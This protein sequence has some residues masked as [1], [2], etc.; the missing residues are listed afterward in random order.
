VRRSEASG[1]K[2]DSSTRGARRGDL[3]G[4]RIDAEASR[5]LTELQ[6]LPFHPLAGLFPLLEGADFE[7]LIADVRAMTVHVPHQRDLFDTD[8]PLIGLHV[9]LD[10]DID[11]RQPCHDNIAEI[12]SGCGPHAYALLCATCGQFRGWLPKAAATFIAEAI[13]VDGIPDTPLI[14]RDA[15]HNDNESF[16]AHERQRRDTPSA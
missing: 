11:R 9:Q 12:C 10:R 5:P 13:R 7:E 4:R 2:R 3:L 8:D 6:A 16:A 14:Y 15:S 1:P